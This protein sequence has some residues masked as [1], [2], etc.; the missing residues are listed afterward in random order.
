M[1]LVA[2]TEWIPFAIGLVAGV[3]AFLAW[4]TW[5]VGRQRAGLEDAA[6]AAAVPADVPAARPLRSAT[7]V[8][9]VVATRPEP[10]HYVVA[11][12]DERAVRI[13][14]AR[15]VRP[16]TPLPVAVPPEVEPVAVGLPRSA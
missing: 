13:A 15:R 12:P 10:V 9:A 1:S 14:M 16:P 3:V 8:R 7:P 5:A 11:A 2:G 6:G 4:S